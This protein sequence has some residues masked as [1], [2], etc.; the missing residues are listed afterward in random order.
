M[1]R[2]HLPRA[3]GRGEGLKWPLGPLPGLGILGG[4][5]RH[6]GR[7]SLGLVLFIVSTG[8]IMYLASSICMSPKRG[9]TCSCC[10][11]SKYSA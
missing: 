6:Y 8:L 4:A 7:H 9:T 11:G 2:I 10:K 3:L 5:E 1:D